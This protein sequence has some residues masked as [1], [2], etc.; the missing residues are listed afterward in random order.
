M[1]KVTLVQRRGKG[2]PAF[3]VPSHRFSITS[4]YKTY[5]GVQ[6]E[7]VIKGDVVDLV[8]DRIRSAPLAKVLFED[9]DVT[10]TPAV[11][12]LRVGTRL[13]YGSNAKISKGNVLP[14]SEVPEGT[15]VCNIERT[16][17]DGGQF[18][19]SSGSWAV[20]LTKDKKSAYVR[21]PSKKKVKF[22]LA[23]RVTLGNVAG[24]GRKEKPLIK[25]GNAFF[26]HKVKN[27]RWPLVRGVA[28]NAVNHKH[29]GAQHHVGKATTVSRHARPGQKVGH[30]AARRTGR[31]KK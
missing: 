30:I 27:R 17:G 22:N 5:D 9:G 20:V 21:L 8:D 16:P 29:G 31:K 26:K 3:K 1:G 7:G 10:F 28:M 13:E 23:C 14:L 4:E 18:V 24:G 12:G 15:P 2:S 6:K 11:E 19:R 25:A